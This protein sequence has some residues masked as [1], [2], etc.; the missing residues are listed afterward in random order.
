MASTPERYAVVS[1]HVERPLDDAVWARFR[2]VQAARPG[3]FAIAALVRPPDPA[4]GESEER[5][6]ERAREAATLGPFG[7]HPHWTS[8]SHA[9]PTAGDPAERVRREGAWLR[10]HGLVPTLFCGGGWHTD[11]GVAAACAELGYADCTPRARRP[12]YLPENAPWA[13]LAAPATVVLPGGERLRCLPTTHGLGDLARALL[14]PSD[15]GEEVVHAYFHDTDL[16]RPRRRLALLWALRV[17][18][19]RRRPTDLDAL[20]RDATPLPER[21]WEGIARGGDAASRT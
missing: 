3:G 11:A 5:W 6:L 18:G 20:A 15:P 12:A 7:H 1:C 8:P 10:G 16:L 4:S 2:A 19:R 21:C 17:L 14:R 9:R 13:E